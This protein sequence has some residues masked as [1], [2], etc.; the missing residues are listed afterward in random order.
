MEIYLDNSAE[1]KIDD[2]VLKAIEN[3]Y[4]NYY[5]NP[6]SLHRLGE[7]SLDFLDLQKN[8]ISK[9][10]NC[11]TSELIFTATGTESINLAIKGLINSQ[12]KHIITSAIEHSSVFESCNFLKNL[13]FKITVLGV[14]KEGFI[15]L[16]KLKN[17]I[18][19]DTALVS[20]Q[21]VN[22]EIGTIQNIKEI[23]NLC[24]SCKILFHSDACQAA[25]EDLNMKN[26]DLLTLNGNKLHGPHIGLLYSKEGIKLEPIT[27]G[28]G[29]QNNKRSGTEDLPY[30]CG[31]RLAL[32]KISENKSEE[33]N[34]IKDLRDKLVKGILEIENTYLIGPKE[35]RSCNNASIVFK[36][37]SADSLILSLSD[38]K[39]YV[40][41]GAACASRFKRA[42][43]VLNAINLDKNDRESSLRF[44]LSRYTKEEEIM[45]A[46][47][48]IKKVVDELRR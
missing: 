9:I 27:H 42:S 40:S 3:T 44:T 6:S 5:G 16:E 2:D 1:T 21:Y 13:G 20:I 18:T 37:L 43:H 25:Y 48:I 7:K 32:E 19:K 35:N 24:K 41:S 28:G 17:A 39:V 36:G 23:Y 38:N 8:K 33:S 15:D 22:N 46:V 10:L 45:E 34:K 11:K 31:F 12:K 4:K 47:R 14:N 26:F 30:I 29:Q